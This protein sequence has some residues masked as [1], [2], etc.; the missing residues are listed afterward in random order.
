MAYAV[1]QDS[2]LPYCGPPPFDYFWLRTIFFN[3]F[4]SREWQ[5][6]GGYVVKCERRVDV[7]FVHSHP[8]N[9]HLVCPPF[10]IC[11]IKI[12]LFPFFLFFISM[13]YICLG[14]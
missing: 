7:D 5:R 12:V 9:L 4:L 13:F 10:I 1:I 14:N 11:P 8:I 6:V 2:F 3:L